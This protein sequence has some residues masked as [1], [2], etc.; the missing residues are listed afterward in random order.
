MAVHQKSS[1]SEVTAVSGR[2]TEVSTPDGSL[3]VRLVP[4]DRVA[5]RRDGT[6]TEDLFAACVSASFLASV[7]ACAL[8]SRVEIPSDLHVEASFTI[9]KEDGLASVDL[10][11][12]VHIPGV[13]RANVDSL[14]LE[15][16][17]T[18]PYCCLLSESHGVRVVIS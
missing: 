5:S 15:A 1:R 10:E 2:Q 6:T 17:G 16:L 4:G 8:A 7:R 14:A 3:N 9:K 13:S 12:R 11:L 18:C